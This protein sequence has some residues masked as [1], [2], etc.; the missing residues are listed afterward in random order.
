MSVPIVLSTIAAQPNIA[1]MQTTIQRINAPSVLANLPS[2]ILVRNISG[3]KIRFSG[4]SGSY[5][6][7]IESIDVSGAFVG[8]TDNTV[9][10]TVDG[11]VV[12]YYE[13][14]V[15]T[16]SI[17]GQRVITATVNDS[18]QYSSV[19]NNCKS[20]FV[21]D[22]TSPIIGDG[23]IYRC[24][25]N[26][27]KD[28]DGTY[29]YLQL[30]ISC[31]TLT[32]NTVSYNTLSNIE[33]SYKEAAEAAAAYNATGHTITQNL[34]GNSSS[35]TKIIT[36]NNNTLT[37]VTSS[38]TTSYSGFSPTKSYTFKVVLTDACGT[39]SEREF[40]LNST[41]YTIHLRRN[42]LGVAFGMM[43]SQDNRVEISPNWDLYVKNKVVDPNV[44]QV[45]QGA[46]ANSDGKAGVVP[47]PTK[48]LRNCFLKGDGT[49][50]EIPTMKPYQAE[51][52]NIA[53]QP[54]TAGLVP[55]PTEAEDSNKFL[56]G[57]GTWAGIPIS[58]FSSWSNADKAA[59]LNFLY[60]PGYWYLYPLPYNSP[61][62]NPI[63]GFFNNVGAYS[64]WDTPAAYGNF[65]L[66]HR[67]E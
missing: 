15:P 14:I 53:A 49:W 58:G 64:K 33:I 4:V 22:Y 10:E 28:D 40:Y 59:L 1:Q 50:S 3:A 42:G 7:T 24:Q 66:N 5:G 35:F 43:S 57:D 32:Y 67:T 61:D 27:T 48:E 36:L 17:A 55:A 12:V 37:A 63:K 25:T 18:R 26:G 9:S 44:F 38:N 21:M 30:P 56:K 16:V 47:Q 39:S 62:N 46:S 31:S 41:P 2:D 13:A 34:N 8:S 23:T 19:F 60:P 54:G 6:A 11:N 52:G 20:F 29:C 65:S 51:A 45:M